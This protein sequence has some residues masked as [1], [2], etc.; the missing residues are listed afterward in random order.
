MRSMRRVPERIGLWLAEAGMSGAPMIPLLIYLDSFSA[1]Q[2]AFLY[3][4][5]FVLFYSFNKTGVFILEAFGTLNNTYR[6][7]RLSALCVIFGCALSVFGELDLVFS[8]LGASLVGLGTGVFTPMYHTFKEMLKKA[9]AWAYGRTEVVGELIMIAVVV[10]L[11]LSRGHVG[12]VVIAAYMLMC[13]A[14]LLALRGLPV[15]EAKMNAPLFVPSTHDYRKLIPAALFFAIIFFVRLFKQ[16]ASSMDILAILVATTLVT[17]VVVLRRTYAAPQIF[18]Y[19]GVFYS[20]IIIFAILYELILLIVSGRFTELL[21]A[22]VLF[23]SGSFLAMLIGGRVLPRFDGWSASN[24]LIMLL[25]AASVVFLFD[26]TGLIALFLISFLA[27][28]GRQRVGRI[29]H[30]NNIGS[31]SSLYLESQ[32]MSNIGFIVGQTILVIVMAVVSVMFFHNADAIMSVYA[33]QIPRTDLA[34]DFHIIQIVCAVIFC[35]QGA[36][37]LAYEKIHHGSIL[38]PH[39]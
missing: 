32:K 26:A 4:L 33:F 13:V 20:E 22:F 10:A 11:F 19:H 6:I 21:V 25:M 9:G 39:A 35:L 37:I 15:P 31:I 24:I 2:G 16:T 36:T 28:L 1:H 34:V 18:E 38:K 7:A 17:L 27:A 29:Y 30:R 3:V 14:S 5:P 12:A 23:L 8:D